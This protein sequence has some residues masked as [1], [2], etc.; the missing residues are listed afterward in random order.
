MA[1]IDVRDLGRVRAILG[2]LTRHGFGSLLHGAGL[3]EYLDRP[4]PGAD[5]ALP[6]AARL[7]A[8]LVELGPSFVKLGQVLSVRPDIIPPA[9]VQEFRTLQDQV[10]PAP[11]EQV[12]PAVEA[13]LGEPLD[14]RFSRFDPTPVASASIAQVHL[15]TL[16]D[17]EGERSVAVKVQRP[18]IERTIRSDLHILFTLAHLLEGRLE[19]PGVYTPVAIVQEFEAAVRQELD[20]LTEASN[21]ERLRAHLRGVPG[22]SAPAPHRRWSTPRLLV[23]DRVEG[24]P[25]G[26]LPPGDPRLPVLLGQLVDLTV[27][28]VFDWGFFHAD[29]HPGNL[30]ATADGGLVLLDLGL[31]GTLTAEMRDT[32]V[33]LLAC[34]VFEDAETLALTLYRVGGVEGRLELRAFRSELER[35]MTRYRGATLSQLS[36]PDSL[37]EFIALC[38]RYRLRLLPE[39]ALLARALSIVDG[40]LRQHL[41][42]QDPVALVRPHAARLL[43]ERLSP[44]RLRTDALRAALQAQGGLKGLPIQLNQLLMDLERG[45]LSVQVQTPD[46][47]PVHEAV[48][49]AALRVSLAVCASAMLVTSAIL[50]AAADPRPFDLP[51]GAALAGLTA[52]I[53]SALWLGL[54]AHTLLGP[55]LRWSEWQ[56]RGMALLRFFAG[57]RR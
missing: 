5:S 32:L 35:M 50:L 15:A 6:W 1:H 12:R 44:E 9:L 46:L 54:V 10:P 8:V 31:C 53:G 40:M 20:F 16:R 30:F 33:T 41:P 45:R 28:Q 57:D 17:G 3:G 49:D 29:P 27:R 7:R 2:V 43:A 4:D 18:G 23:M 42:G 26:A 52:L 21:L 56:R 19:L 55:Q 38:S 34:L 36:E 22:V 37:L 39:Y 24:T 13:E 14:A 47:R 51:L 48:H 25:L 11:W